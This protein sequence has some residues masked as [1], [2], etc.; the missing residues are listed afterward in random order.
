MNTLL[1]IAVVAG[2]TFLALFL[3]AVVMTILRE[4]RYAKLPPRAAFR[5][6]SCSSEQIDILSSGLWDGHDAQGCSTHGIFEYGVCKQCNGRCA[7][8][9]D[10]QAFVPTDEQWQ[11]H[12]GPREKMHRDR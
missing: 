5:C 6:P 8:F 11:S 10:D 2:V 7:R 3:W 4:R 1:I 9:V 12:F